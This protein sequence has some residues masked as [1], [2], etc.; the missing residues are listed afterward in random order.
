MQKQAALNDILL[1]T[2]NNAKAK[3]KEIYNQNDKDTNRA[4][5]ILSDAGYHFT[6]NFFNNPKIVGFADDAKDLLNQYANDK[7]E[8]GLDKALG[9]SVVN[10]TKSEENESKIRDNFSDNDKKQFVEKYLQ[11]NNDVY[12]DEA[13]L[14]VS[15]TWLEDI[16]NDSSLL[17]Y[18][19]YT[20]NK[21]KGI[22]DYYLQDKDVV[23]A[24]VNAIDLEN[25]DISIPENLLLDQARQILEDLAKSYE[26]YQSPDGIVVMEK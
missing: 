25:L 18:A 13:V 24:I 22:R 20:L 7:L 23:D 9:D 16:S 19:L 12:E 26:V 15:K 21:D 1:N 14:N 10:V 17:P 5:Q 2:D 8:Q 11:K 4:I 6:K 3:M